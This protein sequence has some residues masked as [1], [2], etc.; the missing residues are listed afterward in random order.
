[1]TRDDEKLQEAI[2]RYMEKNGGKKGSLWT[3]ARKCYS[4]GWQARK[5]KEEQ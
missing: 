5:K 3:L 2:M 4:I 1:M